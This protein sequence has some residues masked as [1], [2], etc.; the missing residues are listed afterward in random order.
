MGTH[1][2]RRSKVKSG[3]VDVEHRKDG[4]TRTKEEAEL[5]VVSSIS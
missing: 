4:D 5:R 2:E 1:N 3:V